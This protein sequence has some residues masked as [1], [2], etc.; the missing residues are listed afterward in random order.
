VRLAMRIPAA[1]A[2]ALTEFEREGKEL[3]R[4]CDLPGKVVLNT[5]AGRDGANRLGQVVLVAPEDRARVLTELQGLAGEWAT[6]KRAHWPR[7]QVFDG[8]QAPKLADHSL[9]RSADALGNPIDAKLLASWAASPKSSL[10]GGLG[11]HDWR[12][13]DGPIPLLLGREYAVHGEAAAILRRLPNQNLLVLGGSA[14]ARLGMLS[15]IVASACALGRDVL[16]DLRVIDLSGDPAV[17]AAL[18]TG[19]D[20]VSL[21]TY[22]AHAVA[23]LETPPIGGPELLLLIE[24]DRAMDLL[25]PTDPLA[26]SA[27]SDALEKRLR[28]GPPAGRHTVLICTGLSAMN[29]V[30]GRRGVNAFAWRAVTQISQEDSQDLLGNR[31]G[32]Q[33]RPE[34]RSGPEAALLADV[35]GNRFTRF[36][37]YGP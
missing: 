19:G 32:S 25:R 11:R 33:L 29:R 27:G 23:A 7:T 24:P 5:A 9:R 31:Q 2:Q 3:I 30:L 12:P 13:N 36:M 26:R 8:S 22:P 37:P 4:A 34:G 14:P 16:A 28:D 15:G 10:S 17:S 1:A 20:R 35:D 21:V 6:A 18:A